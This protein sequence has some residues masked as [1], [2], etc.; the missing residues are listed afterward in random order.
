MK[1][2]LIKAISVILALSLI[3]CL[4]ASCGNNEAEY[5]KTHEVEMNTENPKDE[6]KYEVPDGVNPLTG[7]TDLTKEAQDTRPVAFMI[8]NT[9]EAGVPW[10]LSTADFVIEGLISEEKMGMM[11]V[12]GDSTKIPDKIGPIAEADDHF[13]KLAKDMN[14]FYVYW[15]NESAEKTDNIDGVKYQST[16]FFWDNSNSENY[17]YQRATSKKLIQSAI[18]QLG[19]SKALESRDY[20]PY[21]VAV[22]GGKLPHT[23]SEFSGPCSAVTI[24]FTENLVYNFQYDKTNG[25]YNKF[26]NEEAVVDEG[27]KANGYKNVIYI[28][29][30]IEFVNGKAQWKYGAEGRGSYVS[31][32]IGQRIY[33]KIDSETKRLALYDFNYNPLIVNPGNVWLGV[34]PDGN[35]AVAV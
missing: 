7:K 14:A 26:I 15:G 16:Y 8:A 9:P 17:E 21:H 22:E 25:V 31:N 27:G 24:D 20:A 10:G 2:K 35:T 18:S 12:Y 33:W 11:W 29:V 3:M 30:P 4:F 28:F 34:V 32:G 19:Y 5:N 6:E 23:S 13:A 1:E